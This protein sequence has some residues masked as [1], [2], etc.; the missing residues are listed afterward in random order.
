MLLLR[1]LLVTSMVAGYRTEGATPPGLGPF[2]SVVL[3]QPVPGAARGFAH[4]GWRTGK[5]C[6]MSAPPFMA[7][8]NSN[9]TVKATPAPIAN[10]KIVSRRNN[11]SRALVDEL[12]LEV[13]LTT[14]CCMVAEDQLFSGTQPLHGR[15]AVVRRDF[16]DRPIGFGEFDS[17]ARRGEHG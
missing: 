14:A 4:G 2:G 16:G 12:I 6:N 5:L 7:L 17:F 3:P 8:N 13:S 15:R 9:A 10:V 1:A 11:V